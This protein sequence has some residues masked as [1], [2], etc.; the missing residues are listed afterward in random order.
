MLSHIYL[1]DKTM[2]TKQCYSSP[3]KEICDFNDL[4][5]SEKL[6]DSGYFS[7]RRLNI[8]LMQMVCVAVLC[9][10]PGLDLHIH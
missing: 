3:K 9:R 10:Q 4:L 7:M 5:K 2:I 1:I 8:Q 6:R